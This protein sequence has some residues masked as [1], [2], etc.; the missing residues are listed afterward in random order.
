MKKWDLSLDKNCIQ[1]VMEII[2]V[3]SENIAIV[4]GKSMDAETDSPTV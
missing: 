4:T 3:I 1:N 2:R